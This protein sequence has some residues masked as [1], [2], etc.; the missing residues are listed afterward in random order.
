MVLMGRFLVK[1]WFVLCSW[2][3]V[4][5]I[6]ALRSLEKLWANLTGMSLSP[7]NAMS[8]FFLLMFPHC[9]TP[10]ESRTSYAR[11]FEQPSNLPRVLPNR[12]G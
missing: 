5:R 8:I 3:V 6:N 10:E 12:P 11:G 9:D 7:F 4:A 2:L 1:S